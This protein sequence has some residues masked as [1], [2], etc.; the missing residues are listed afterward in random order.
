MSHEIQGKLWE[1][2][3]ADIFTIHNRQYVCIVDYHNKFSILK[4]VEGFSADNLIKHVRSFF[5]SMDCPAK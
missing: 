2:V 5:Q 1:S 4:Q 3:G